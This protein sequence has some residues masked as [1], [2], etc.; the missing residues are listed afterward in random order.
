MPKRLFIISGCSTGIGFGLCQ[1]FAQQGHRVLA[2]YRSDSDK[3]QL[4][5]VPNVIPLVLDVTKEEHIQNLKLKIEQIHQSDEQVCLVNN[6]GIS[7]AGALETLTLDTYRQVFEVNVFGVI[8]LTQVCLPFLRKSKGWVI[9]ISSIS[10]LLS[11]PYMGPYAGSKFALEA[12]AESLREEVED[13]GV[14]VVNIN[15]GYI[16]TPI[17]NKAKQ[18]INVMISD[19]PLYKSKIENFSQKF[20]KK[21]RSKLSPVELVWRAIDKA[22]ASPNPKTNY[23]V[24]KLPVRILFKLLPFLPKKLINR[25]VRS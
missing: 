11:S 22:M 24:A 12:I 4:E 9:N 1:H 6:A 17:W 21:I 18:N 10:G 2:G 25:L 8:R 19:N 20:E 13:F 14:R 16:D 15:P 3:A 23:L 7:K 5:K